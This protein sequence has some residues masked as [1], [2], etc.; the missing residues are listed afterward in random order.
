LEKNS[1]AVV[2]YGQGD[3]GNGPYESEIIIV[4]NLTKLVKTAKQTTAEE[5]FSKLEKYEVKLPI[6]NDELYLEVHRGCPTTHNDLKYFNKKCEIALN[7]VEKLASLAMCT[8]FIYPYT[9]LKEAWKKVL[10]NQFH[11]ILPGSG[12]QHVYYGPGCR[13][14]LKDYQITLE[15]CEKIQ[16]SIIKSFISNND[17]H[18]TYNLGIFFPNQWKKPQIVEIPGDFEN[19]QLFQLQD[20]DN[21]LL[22]A[23]LTTDVDSGKQLYRF[24][25]VNPSGIGIMQYKLKNNLLTQENLET[26]WKIENAKE[27][28]IYSNNYYKVSV[29]KKDGSIQE[30][31]IANN[32]ANL[33]KNGL[34]LLRTFDDRPKG[35]DAWNIDESYR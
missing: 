29:S 27:L 14:S 4:D 10:F 8:G 1:S 5:F 22:I 26:T 12:I 35:N 13:Y 20:P 15:I 18:D 16:E 25:G 17:I 19:K 34:N 33:A 32:K 30:L 23:Q 11:D 21:Q 24:V 9:Q 3:G 28:I 6:W 7:Q 2:C 31:F